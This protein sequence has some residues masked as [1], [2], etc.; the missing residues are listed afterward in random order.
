MAISFSHLTNAHITTRLG[1]SMVI[2][3]ILSLE[4][5]VNGISQGAGIYLNKPIKDIMTA[6][7]V[8]LLVDMLTAVERSFNK[9]PE[10]RTRT[11]VDLLI[12]DIVRFCDRNSIEAAVF[13]EFPISQA[14]HTP[15]MVMHS[16]KYITYL[17]GTADYASVTST[18]MNK[19]TELRIAE[20]I[21]GGSDTPSTWEKFPRAVQGLPINITE[22]K[23]KGVELRNHLPQAV[24]EC[25]AL[26][27]KASDRFP[28]HIVPFC[29]TTG[30]RW[31]FGIVDCSEEDNKRCLTTPEF[32][33]D[34]MDT[35]AVKNILI[36]LFFWATEDASVLLRRISDQ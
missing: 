31:I 21:P 23:K 13:P 9:S 15:G 6:W 16:E 22:L 18:S 26:R 8:S 20:T 30:E 24:G 12:I 28:M 19:R 25:V 35:R 32:S 2:S 34:M 29:L 3:H 1:I 36:L 33:V 10:A 7:D 5:L 4:S 27:S 17:T 11:I 14:E